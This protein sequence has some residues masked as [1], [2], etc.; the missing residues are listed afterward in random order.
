MVAAIIAA[1]VTTATEQSRLQELK[2][3]VKSFA[4]K[5]MAIVAR[6]AAA[7]TVIVGV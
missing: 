4:A 7:A 6:T 3:V 2:G 5:A 1:V